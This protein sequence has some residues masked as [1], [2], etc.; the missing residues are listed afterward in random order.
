MKGLILVALTATAGLALAACGEGGGT[1]TARTST[2]LADPVLSADFNHCPFNDDVELSAG[3]WGGSVA[4]DVSCEQAGELIQRHFD[5]DA[6]ESG[7]LNQS[8]ADSIRTSDPQ[9]FAS[10]GYDCATF[11]LPDGMGWH[12][13]CANAIAQISFYFTP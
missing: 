4:G 2:D 5:R 13:L 11:P 3:G 9:R 8:D 6:G 1:A 7:A 12:V 10:A